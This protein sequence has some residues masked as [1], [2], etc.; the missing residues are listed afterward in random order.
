[1]AAPDLRE[2][3]LAAWRTY[4]RVTVFLVEQLPPALGS[5]RARGSAS[6]GPHD[7]RTYPQRSVHVDQDGR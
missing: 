4:N 3:I 2:R 6:H 7:R 5:E 1:M